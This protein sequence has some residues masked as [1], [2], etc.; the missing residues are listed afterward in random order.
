MRPRSALATLSCLALALSMGCAVDGAKDTEAGSAIC[1]A[2]LPVESRAAAADGQPDP[3]LAA[4]LL[5]TIVANDCRQR[6]EA[7]QCRESY[8]RYG[9][10]E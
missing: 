3:E 5:C 1:S 10:A 4:H 6:P 9:L 7:Q 8:S 2:C